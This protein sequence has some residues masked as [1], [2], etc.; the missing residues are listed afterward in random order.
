[1]LRHLYKLP[2]ILYSILI[3]YLSSLPQRDLPPIHI[4]GFDKIVHSIE[5]L[6]YGMTLMLAY[7]QSKSSFIFKNAVTFSVFTGLIYAASDEIHQL[8]IAGRDCNF[9]DFSADA[10]GVIFGIILFSKIVK[11]DNPDDEI[12]YQ[13][14]YHK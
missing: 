4:F 5:Y 1:M 13:Q 12:F 14:I 2:A 7:T 9:W 8:F 10:F 11:Y 3:F 6:L